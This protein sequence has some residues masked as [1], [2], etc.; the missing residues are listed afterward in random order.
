MKSEYCAAT[1]IYILRLLLLQF[2]LT[3]YWYYGC[4]SSHTPNAQQR[5]FDDAV[6][7]VY[8]RQH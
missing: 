1:L 5:R 7:G 2:L 3:M 4:T 6:M 8:A